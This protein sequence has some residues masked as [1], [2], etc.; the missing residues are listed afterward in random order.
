MEPVILSDLDRV[1]YSIVYI[2]GLDVWLLN[3]IP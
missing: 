2:Y 1:L 3:V